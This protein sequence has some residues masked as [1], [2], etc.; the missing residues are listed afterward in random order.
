MRQIHLLFI[1]FNTTIFKPE[2]KGVVYL[3]RVGEHRNR[4]SRLNGA[5]ID[6][7]EWYH[8]ADAG[9]TLGFRGFAPSRESRASREAAKARRRAVNIN[10]M[11]VDCRKR[12]AEES[13]QPQRIHR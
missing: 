12:A 6:Y 10:T 1:V 4:N 11:T 7:Q 13:K 9:K 2:E 3:F 8:G 5:D